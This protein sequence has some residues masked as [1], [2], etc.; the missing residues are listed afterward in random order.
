MSSKKKGKTKKTTAPPNSEVVF[1][2]DEPVKKKPK[3]PVVHNNNKQHNTANQDVANNKSGLRSDFIPALPP[4]V[5][6]YIFD[7]AGFKCLLRCATICRSW[8]DALRG[9][10]IWQWRAE[11]EGIP[12]Q[13]EPKLAT[14][15]FY[16]Y[17]K[18]RKALWNWRL[19]VFLKKICF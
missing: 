6:K 12:V 5:I 7:F 3:Q 19:L 2:I 15:C 11:Q 14:S 9:D 13:P 4:D 8:R 18:E 1:E 10:W 17:L 16:Q